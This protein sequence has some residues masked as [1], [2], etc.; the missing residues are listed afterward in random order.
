M[1]PIMMGS[2]ASTLRTRRSQYYQGGFRAI[3]RGGERT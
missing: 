2:K 3:S 1:T